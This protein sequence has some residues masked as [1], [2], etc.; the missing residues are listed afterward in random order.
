MHK[1]VISVQ[2]LITIIAVWKNCVKRTTR[3]LLLTYLNKEVESDPK[4]GYSYS[5]I[6]MIRHAQEEYGRALTSVDLALKYLPKKDCEFVSATYNIRAGVYL[7]LEDTVK[8]LNDYASSI[9]SCPTEENAYEKR[10]QVY[11]EQGKYDL[12]SSERH[13]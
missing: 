7:A 8:T 4:N 9:K 12:R 6:A 5:W 1:I 3:K 13:R 2:T 10:A 11:Y